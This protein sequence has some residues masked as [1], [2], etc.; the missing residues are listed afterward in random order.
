MMAFFSDESSLTISVQCECTSGPCCD[1]CYFLSSSTV[2]ATEYR[3]TSSGCGAAY[4]KRDRY[5]S[6]SSASCDGSWT[7][8][9]TIQDC[10]SKEKCYLTSPHCQTVPECAGNPNVPELISPENNS[11]I[12]QNPTL[13]VRVSDPNNKQ[14]RAEF[15]LY[16]DFNG[17]RKID[18]GEYFYYLSDFYPSGSNIS[19][20][21]SLPD[22]TPYTWRAR[23]RNEDGYWSDWPQFWTF[24]KDTIP[25]QAQISYNLECATSSNFP[26]YLEESDNLAG[27]KQGLVQIS[28]EG[29]DWQDYKQTT[30]DFTYSGKEGTTYQFRYRVQDKAGN[31]SDWATGPSQTLSINHP[32]TATNLRVQ[33]TDP[34]DKILGA[35]LRWDFSDPDGDSQYARHIQIDDD[36]DFSSPIIDIYDEQFG[37]T[38]AYAFQ[39]KIECDK[40]YYWRVKVWDSPCQSSSSWIEGPSFS[41]QGLCYY[42]IIDFSWR[43]QRISF[44]QPIQFIDQSTCYDESSLGFDCSSEDPFIDSFN[45]HFLLTKEDEWGE[46]QTIFETST[47]T[48]NPVITL[49]YMGD[50]EITLIVTD[51]Q[52]RSCP[53]T[54]NTSSRFPVWVW[55]TW[56]EINPACFWLRKFPCD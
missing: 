50:L 46:T 14:V 33:L 56:R 32:P 4:Q 31:L 15:E 45:W 39:E 27:I 22:F 16:A 49:P 28:I 9:Q 3:C 36:S 41:T 34:C 18:E 6:G 38:T 40:T 35:L 2:C 42:P 20:S 13:T 10:S 21:L 43:P 8:W 17:N 47:T 12:N 23:A 55:K 26:V 1:G 53:K 37:S 24:H 54:V 51:S 44:S 25:P 19:W 11:W 7:S 5:C 48:E 30:E 52:G 29:G